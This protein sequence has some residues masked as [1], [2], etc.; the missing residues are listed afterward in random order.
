MFFVVPKTL[1]RGFALNDDGYRTIIYT[2]NLNIAQPL[3]KKTRY[4][5]TILYIQIRGVFFVLL[6]V[7]IFFDEHFPSCIRPPQSSGP[8]FT[9]THLFRCGTILWKHTKKKT[10]SK[11]FMTSSIHRK[12]NLAFD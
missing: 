7:R 11:S 6:I 8:R 10:A 4:S 2:Q 9:Y 3:K 5:D 1:K 12:E